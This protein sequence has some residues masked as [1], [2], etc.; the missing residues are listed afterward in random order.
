M[1]PPSSSIERPVTL[2]YQSRGEGPALVMLHGLYGSGQNWGRH[3]RRLGEAYRVITPDLRNHGR[4]PHATPMTYPAMAADVLAL[5]DALEIETANIIGHS[6]GGKVAMYTALDAPHRVQRLCAVDIAP[7]AYQGNQGPI[8]Q[9]MRA[10]E[11]EALES[12]Q[13]ADD[14]LARHIPE[15]MV[16]QFLL[17]NLESADNGGYR[18]RIPLDVLADAL[19]DIEGFPQTDKRYPGPAHFIHGGQSDY[20]TPTGREAIQSYFPGARI[21]CVETAGHWVHVEAPETFADLVGDWLATP[22]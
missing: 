15:T 17:T 16:R 19:E 8:I 5:L 13:A 18:W 2:H 21:H 7:L 9:A 11:P 12:R 1:T 4:S 3:V 20:V 22:V 6:M 14:T 10:V